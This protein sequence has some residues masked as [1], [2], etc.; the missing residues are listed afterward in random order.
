MGILPPIMTRRRH[1]VPVRVR[2]PHSKQQPINQLEDILSPQEKAVTK[3]L[4]RHHREGGHRDTRVH[5]AC[6]WTSEGLKLGALRERGK[7]AQLKSF[8]RHLTKEVIVAARA[9]EKQLFDLEVELT[10]KSTGAVE[11][12]KIQVSGTRDI[13]IACSALHQVGQLEYLDQVIDSWEG[14][15]G[16]DWKEDAAS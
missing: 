7:D 6:G 14:R 8:E 15:E 5:C 13:A 9:H 11:N 4:R 12:V 1:L 16:W 10:R 2:A 3:A